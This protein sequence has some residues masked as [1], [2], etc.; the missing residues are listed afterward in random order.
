VI[1]LF[2]LFFWAPPVS[3][4]YPPVFVFFAAPAYPQTIRF[5]GPLPCDFSFE[6]LFPFPAGCQGPET[7]SIGNLSSTLRPLFLPPK[8][9]PSLGPVRSD[10]AFALITFPW[11]NPEST[12][13]RFFSGLSHLFFFF[14]TINPCQEAHFFYSAGSSG[15]S[16]VLLVQMFRSIFYVFCRH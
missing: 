8:L 3:P 11:S 13:L 16:L 5:L 4:R 14:L 1:L 6:F 12:S 9:M 15:N 2:L 10:H 7:P